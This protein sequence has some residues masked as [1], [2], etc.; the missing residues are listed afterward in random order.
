MFKNFN[1]QPGNNLLFNAIKRK[2]GYSTKDLQEYILLINV[3]KNP[4]IANICKLNDYVEENDNDTI[5]DNLIVNFTFLYTKYRTYGTPVAKRNRNKLY[6][7]M[8]KLHCL[9]EGIYGFNIIKHLPPYKRR[10][11]LRK[12]KEYFS[13]YH[14]V[15]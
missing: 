3:V 10:T 13:L 12:Q 14:F 8:C 7:N 15:M 6:Y 4:T 2:Q 5:H 9:L 1:L 11:L